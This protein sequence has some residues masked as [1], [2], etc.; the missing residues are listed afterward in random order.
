[1]MDYLL[2]KGNGSEYKTKS[3]PIHSNLPPGLSFGLKN[4]TVSH[5]YIAAEL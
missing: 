1:M 5:D 4:W 2:I 3:G